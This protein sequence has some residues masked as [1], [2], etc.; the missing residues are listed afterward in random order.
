MATERVLRLPFLA[1][2]AFSLGA[3][4]ASARDSPALAVHISPAE[5]DLYAAAILHWMPIIFTPDTTWPVVCGLKGRSRDPC[6][7]AVTGD[8]AVEWTAYV[9]ANKSAFAIDSVELTRRGVQLAGPPPRPYGFTGCAPSPV[10][11]R[12]SRAGFN[13]DSTEAI[14]SFEPLSVPDAPSGCMIVGG[15]TALY[16]KAADGSWKRVKY[17]SAWMD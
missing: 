7:L 13:R 17:L 9:A 6:E 12:I 15:Q 2:L 8:T 1:V 3:C 14:L 10:E 4:S 5:Y 11:I 16:Q